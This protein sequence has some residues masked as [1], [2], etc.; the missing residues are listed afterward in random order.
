MNQGACS[1]ILWPI[2][3]GIRPKPG[4]KMNQA[5]VSFILWP[6]NEKTTKHGR[7][8]ATRAQTSLYCRTKILLHHAADTHAA[9]EDVH[10]D[11]AILG[12]V[13]VTGLLGDGVA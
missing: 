9:A 11:G 10:G 5:A 7:H 12:L 13:V 8:L 6:Q 2:F 4:H 1:F 3:P